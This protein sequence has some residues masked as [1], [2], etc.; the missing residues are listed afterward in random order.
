MKK[1]RKSKKLI[2]KMRVATKSIRAR[3]KRRRV[4]Y[5]LN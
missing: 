1:K 3:R 4:L 2:G 5:F